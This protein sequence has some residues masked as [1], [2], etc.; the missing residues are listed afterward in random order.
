MKR[1]FSF[2]LLSI[3]FIASLSSCK[4]NKDYKVTFFNVGKA[5]AI[6]LQYDDKNMIIDTG[7]IDSSE[8]FINRLKELNV[9]TVDV[10]IITH[11]DQDHVGGASSVV[12]N[13]TVKEVYQTYEVKTSNVLSAFK[14]ALSQKEITPKEVSE[15]TSFYL[16]DVSYTIYPPESKTYNNSQSNNSSLVVRSVY[17]KNSFLFAG[18]AEKERLK[19]LNSKAP[20]LESDVL[21]VPHHGQ[22]EDN[23]STFF[24]KINP[25][26]AIITDSLEEPRDSQVESYLTAMG[27]KTYYTKNGD[28]TITSTGNS[29][30]IKQ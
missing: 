11:F 28:I 13:F 27:V 10:L 24:K 30:S 4:N 7:T 19:E 2:L 22:L 3:I 26:Y 25:S 12:N 14:V 15:E 29:I 23:T 18:D 8:Y 5:D 9:S 1:L 6:L 21:K 16:G 20:N 17:N